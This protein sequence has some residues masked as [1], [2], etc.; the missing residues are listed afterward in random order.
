MRHKQYV[1]FPLCTI[2]A[3]GEAYNYNILKNRKYNLKIK[4]SMKMG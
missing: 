1:N 3:R 4:M 2:D